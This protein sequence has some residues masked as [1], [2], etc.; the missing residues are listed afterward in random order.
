MDRAWVIGAVLVLGCGG[1]SDPPDDLPASR[2]YEE[3]PIGSTMR[4][5]ESCDQWPFAPA[6]GQHERLDMLGDQLVVVPSG[7]WTHDPAFV[8]LD[9][10]STWSWPE[11][12]KWVH[13]AFAAPQGLFVQNN[14]GMLLWTAP[15]AWT[16]EYPPS[17]DEAVFAR[18]GAEVYMFLGTG[19]S[20][21][22]HRTGPG[23]WEEVFTTDVAYDLAI[24]DGEIFVTTGGGIAR[25]NG[26]EVAPVPFP[27]SPAGEELAPYAITDDGEGGVVVFGKYGDRSI[28]FRRAAGA[29]ITL[30]DPPGDVDPTPFANEP[31]LTA[32]GGVVTL[33]DDYVLRDGAWLD[34]PDG[35]WLLSAVGDGEVYA[36]AQEPD[37]PQ[38]GAVAPVIRLGAAGWEDVPVAPRIVAS[39]LDAA[40]PEDAYVT[41]EGR[42]LR[43]DGDRWLEIP[44]FDGFDPQLVSIEPVLTVAGWW[45][46]GERYAV[47]RLTGQTWTME[48]LDLETG[49]E[50]GRFQVG[51]AGEHYLTVDCS[52]LRRDAD[53]WTRIRG[54]G[55]PDRRSS[56]RPVVAVLD[57]GGLVYAHEDYAT[58][59]AAIA[60][61]WDGE[62]WHEVARGELLLGQLRDD[63]GTMRAALVK[64]GRPPQLHRFDTDGT[65]TVIDEAWGL[66][67]GALSGRTFDD[68]VVL[69]GTLYHWNG[70]DAEMG[71]IYGHPES[72]GGPD[73][74]WYDG[75]TAMMAGGPESPGPVERCRPAW[76]PLP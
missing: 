23:A 60:E 46:P 2:P 56:S 47:A 61:L 69:D 49:N 42:L 52:L 11:Q 51:K 55:C 8:L 67:G 66:Q 15:G 72:A 40:S 34:V 29:W 17:S 26:V 50:L 57:G 41:S 48:R 22:L 38:G 64:A 39:D 5:Y 16:T 71:G 24:G 54:D 37:Y 53:G 73:S 20:V 35:E 28:V 18:R 70:A 10:E 76:E 7:G 43:L 4:V 36:I 65:V 21:V 12:P 6:G 45:A 25:W 59:D 33:G 27:Q 58:G 74:V 13:Q 9:G 68:L 62:R 75:T 31:Y 30:P 44:L 3:R 14:E 63:D 1:A 19:P 32:A